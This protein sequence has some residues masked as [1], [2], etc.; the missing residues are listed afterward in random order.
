LLGSSGEALWPRGRPCCAAE[1]GVATLLG[2]RSR[3]G[4][5]GTGESMRAKSAAPRSGVSLLAELLPTRGVMLKA[6]T[7]VGMGGGRR[8]APWNQGEAMISSKLSRECGSV[9]RMLWIR[10]LACSDTFTVSG[11]LY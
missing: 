7:V 8:W 2:D 6:L 10:S 4:K 5:R 3:S 9:R 1:L 11:K